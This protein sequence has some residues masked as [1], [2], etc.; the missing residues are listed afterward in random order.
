MVKPGADWLYFEKAWVIWGAYIFN[1]PPAHDA[2]NFAYF[3]FQTKPSQE[4]HFGCI[5]IAGKLLTYN[6]WFELSLSI[7]NCNY[8]VLVILKDAFERK[9]NILIFPC[10]RSTKMTLEVGSPIGPTCQSVPE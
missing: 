2:R 4:R 7:L 9:N 6:V 10:T 5:V 8:H 1:P 3:K